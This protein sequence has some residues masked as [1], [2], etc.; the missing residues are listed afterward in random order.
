MA[1]PCVFDHSDYPEAFINKFGTLH[2]IGMRS[3]PL[4]V[5]TTVV[6]AGALIP[7]YRGIDDVG[8]FICYSHT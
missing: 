1:E 3:F 8:W 4:I 6:G 2:H 5:F 7:Y